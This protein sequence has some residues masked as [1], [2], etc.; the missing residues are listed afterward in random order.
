MVELIRTKKIEA[1]DLLVDEIVVD[2]STPRF[3]ALDEL[4]VLVGQAKSCII[5]AVDDNKIVGHIIAY[6]PHLRNFVFISSA[7][8]R[9]EYHEIAEEALEMVYDFA[10][11][12]CEVREVRFETER[13]SAALIR[14][15]GFEEL[16]VVMRKF[17]NE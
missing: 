6:K 3:V 11:N 8:L 2:E 13:S 7:R 12:E 15:Y 9:G 10:V 17:I 4:K 14:A 1:L 5:V 16:S